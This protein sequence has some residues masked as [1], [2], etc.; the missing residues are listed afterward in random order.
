MY[1]EEADDLDETALEAI[2]RRNRVK[3]MGTDGNGGR[4]GKRDKLSYEA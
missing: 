4:D 1:G 3:H 2:R